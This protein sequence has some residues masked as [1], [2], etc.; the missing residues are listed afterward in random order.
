MTQL[1]HPALSLAAVRQEIDALDDGIL[2]LLA[3]RFKLVSQVKTL[4]L[5]EPG[6]GLSPLRPAREAQVLRRLLAKAQPLGIPAHLMVCLWPAIFSAASQMQ[7]NVTL[8]LSP[9]ALLQR[10][11]VSG[12]FP[13]MP[14]VI[15]G[16]AGDALRAVA[17]AP[18]H[19]AIVTSGDDWASP[20]ASGLAGEA[21]VIAVLPFI[22]EAVI[23]ELMIVGHAPPDPSGEDETL[24]IS[25]GP[26][27]A[28]FPLPVKWQVVQGSKH[29]TALHGFLAKT[30]PA[31]LQ[32]PDLRILGRYPAPI[33]IET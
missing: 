20:L 8:H 27:P 18:G 24:V 29:V 26:L 30:E 1:P 5:S 9:S 31:L 13:M 25:A 15:A 16:S 10:H 4:K 12:Y 6:E 3:R 7:G 2:D 23:P 14:G 28:S 22:R 32:I 33:R 17:N 11:L 19:A 21:Q